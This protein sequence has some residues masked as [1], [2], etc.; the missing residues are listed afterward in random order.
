MGSEM[1]IRDRFHIHTVHEGHKVFKC[2]TCDKLFTQDSSLNAH[3]HSIHEGEKDCYNCHICPSSFTQPGIL[4]R[5]IYTLHEGNKQFKCG[6]CGKLF[7]HEYSLKK[8]INVIHG[9]KKPKNKDYNCE[10]CGNC[11]LYTSPSPRD[12]STSR[13]PSSA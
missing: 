11:L 10:L 9:G 8:H 2:D 13:M 3:I 4:R 5:H 6:K 12:L 1:C 7:T